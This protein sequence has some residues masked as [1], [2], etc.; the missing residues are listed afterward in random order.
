MPH[1]CLVTGSRTVGCRV[2]IVVWL[3][4]CHARSLAWQAR[5]PVC[6]VGFP[7]TPCWKGSR[8]M[9]FLEKTTRGTARRA[10]ST[11]RPGKNSKSGVHHR[12]LFCISNGLRFQEHSG[13]KSPRRLTSR[14][15]LVPPPCSHIAGIPG[16]SVPGEARGFVRAEN[17]F[18]ES[19]SV[20]GVGGSSLSASLLA[21]VHCP[22]S[23]PGFERVCS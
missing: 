21:F 2:A 4:S 16:F 1:Q 13:R 15:R 6:P 23:E 7:S 19:Q 14:T 17:E 3:P 11:V 9:K 10:R 20:M 12:S 22:R 18:S 8:G 5:R